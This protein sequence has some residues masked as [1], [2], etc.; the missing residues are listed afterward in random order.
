MAYQN[1][2]SLINPFDADIN[3]KIQKNRIIDEP[4]YN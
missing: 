1:T 4:R 2:V 3:S